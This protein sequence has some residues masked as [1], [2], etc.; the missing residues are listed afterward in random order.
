MT[1]EQTRIAKTFEDRIFKAIEN[2]VEFDQVM[3]EFEEWK[4]QV[5]STANK[6]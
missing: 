4:Q 5:L 3:K 2:S 6:E 1:P